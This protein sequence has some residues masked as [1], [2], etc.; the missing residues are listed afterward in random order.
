MSKPR[1]IFVSHSYKDADLYHQLIHELRKR[2]HFKFQN[3]SVPD[4]TLI[5]KEDA[6]PHIRQR[7]K[8]SD[9]ML[10]FTRPIAS[11]SPMIRYEID[12]AKKLGKPIIAIKPAGDRNVSQ[13]VRP[14]PTWPVA[15]K[16]RN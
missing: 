13:V 9:V 8:K 3:V 4:I 1:F 11:K 10:I 6:R 14:P 7:I 16:H 15:S 5:Q 2:P 12:T